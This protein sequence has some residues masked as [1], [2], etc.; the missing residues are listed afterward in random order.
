MVLPNIAVLS[1]LAAPAPQSSTSTATGLTGSAAAATQSMVYVTLAATPEQ[2]KL[3]NLVNATGI[4]AFALTP[5]N[6][7]PDKN[8]VQLHG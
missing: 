4:P 6:I 7:L 3:L 1:V 5:A 2:A 8:P